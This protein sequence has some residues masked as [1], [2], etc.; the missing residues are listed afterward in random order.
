MNLRLMEL[1]KQA[2][3]KNRDAF[4]ER[5]GVNKFTYKSWETGK[6]MMSLA[7]ACRC[8][9]VLGCSL[10]ELVG[11]EWHPSYADPREAEL[12]RCWDASTEENR[13]ALLV[14]ARNSA[15]ES[16]NVAEPAHVRAEGAR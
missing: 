1:R 10:D 8:C 14:M 12:H 16:L 11:R 5:L 4:A 7:Q 6:A 2:G 15:G 3:Y 9:D 13:H